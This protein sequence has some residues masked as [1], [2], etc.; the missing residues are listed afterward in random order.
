MSLFRRAVPLAII[1]TL[2]LNSLPLRAPAMSTQQEV[3]AGQAE[4]EQITRSEVI[5]NDPLLN[6]Y[7]QSIAN[8]LWLQ[9]ERKDVPYNIKVVKASDVNSFATEGGFVYIDEGLIDFVQSDDELAAVIGHETGHIERRHVVTMNSKAEILNLLLGIASIFS[10]FVY[11]FGNLIGATVMAKMS[12]EDELEA[13]RT[14]LQLMARAGYDPEAMVT[15]MKH[16]NVLADEHSDLIDKYLQDHPDPQARV[17]HLV[18]YPEL[19]PT[20]VT[21]QQ[22]LVQAISDEERA[23]YSYGALRLERI[24]ASDPH[25]A[26]ALLRL[27]QAQLALGQTSKS[28]QTLAEAAQAGSTQARALAL[29]REA[30]L[31]EIEAQRVALLRLD[32]DF[33]RLERSIADARQTQSDAA[34]QLE[35]RRN[36][37]HDQLQAVEARLKDVEYEMPELG[38]I[39]IRPNSRLAAIVSNLEAMARA[40]NSGTDDATQV[41]DGVGSLEPG[42]QGGLLRDGH[43]ILDEM[44]APLAMHPVPDESIAIFPSYSRMLDEISSSDGDALRAVDAARASLTLMDQGIADL[45]EFLRSLDQ[46]YMSFGDLAVPDYNGLVPRMSRVMD[47]FNAAAV[48][49]SQADQ[50]YNMARSRQ[51]SVRISLL[52]VGDSSQR[53]ATLQYALQQRFGLDGVPYRA[54][55]HAGVTPGEV[56]AATILAA[57]CKAGLSCPSGSTAQTI[58]DSSVRTKTPVIDLANEYGMHAWPL[59]IFMGLVYLDYTD[60]PTKE[61][62]SGAPS[63]TVG[64]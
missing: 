46:S 30:S 21:E 41:I 13:D 15:M 64:I 63:S 14:G 29:V 12:R 51:L 56:V 54:M 26:E 6:A 16:M 9:V 39:S 1:A 22:K 27:A 3:R 60:D 35:T 31:R 23:R 59:E 52:G 33:G 43:E 24:L 34:Q 19:D 58:V 17:A 44:D 50:L 57:D 32:P 8:K 47:E 25:N 7:V 4:D 2:L 40:V 28:A 18:G 38:N 5:E 37:A 10:P 53:Y 20:K 45:D 61:L 55:L 42:K 36:Q 11:D 62:A 48:A 49:A